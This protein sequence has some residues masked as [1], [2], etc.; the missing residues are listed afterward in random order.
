MLSSLQMGKILSTAPSSDLESALGTP[1]PHVGQ[2]VEDISL[3]RAQ[4]LSFAFS[5]WIMARLSKY[6]V[7]P[8]REQLQAQMNWAEWGA[9][10]L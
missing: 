2:N 5:G 6:Y 9:G 1:L 8:R 3:N 10:L 7:W 4:H